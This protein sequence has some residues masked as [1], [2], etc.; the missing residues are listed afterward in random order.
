MC[1]TE[2]I[3]DLC[4]FLKSQSQAHLGKISKNISTVDIILMFHIFQQIRKAQEMLKP[5]DKIRVKKVWTQ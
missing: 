5:E 1:R 4:G 3:V 2:A